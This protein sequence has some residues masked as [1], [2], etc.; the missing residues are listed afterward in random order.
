VTPINSR[1][2]K[3]DVL[4]GIGVSLLLF[5][6]GAIMR[7]AVTVK[8]DGL[9]LHTAGV[10]LMIVGVVGAVFSAMNWATWGG[11]GG[12]GATTAGTRETITR[13]RDV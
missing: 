1:V 10:I 6:A 7:Y 3:E 11:F 8:A 4:M 2:P 12:R 5:A 9:D 13:E